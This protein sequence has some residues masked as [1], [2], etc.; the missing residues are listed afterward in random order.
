MAS[1]TR[2][3]RAPTVDVWTAAEAE[4]KRR[5]L[6]SVNALVLLLIGEALGSEVVATTRPSVGKP[7][8]R[9]GQQVAKVADA[10]RVAEVAQAVGASTVQVGPQRPPPGARLKR[11]ARP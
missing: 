10:V 11:Q 1:L 6:R 4:A 3:I 8:A 5:G 7:A 2:S 9:P